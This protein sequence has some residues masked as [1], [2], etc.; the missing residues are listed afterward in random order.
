MRLSTLTNS[1]VQHWFD[2]QFNK[3][4]PLLQQLHRQ[5][6]QLA[7]DIELSYGSGIAGVVGRRLAKKMG[8]PSAGQH[9]LKVTITHQ[10]DCMLW[11]R[12]FNSGQILTSK[13][14]PIGD[15]QTGYW[16]EKTG[17][18]TLKLTVDIINGGWH[19]RCLGVELFGLP[20]PRLFVPK[21]TA[22]KIVEGGHYH[23]HVGLALPLFGELVRYSGKL[24]L[25]NP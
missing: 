1:I 6:G 23:F 14:F 16:I 22:F 9:Q 4:D 2:N 20:I 11:Q 21:T 3:L 13:F 8:L 12:C 17:A 18:I 24:N 25:T 5:G 15:I 19:W 10:H 7:G